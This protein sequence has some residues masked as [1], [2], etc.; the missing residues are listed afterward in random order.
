M[1]GFNGSLSTDQMWQVS[2]LLSDAN[3]LPGQC[4]D[5]PTAASATVTHVQNLL[6]ST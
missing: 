5:R 1:P 4:P 2:L 3:K 6:E